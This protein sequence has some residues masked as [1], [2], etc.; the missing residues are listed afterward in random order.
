MSAFTGLSIEEFNRLYPMIADRY[1]DYEKKR[2]SR[3]GRKKDIGQGRKF[4]LD[5]IDRLLMLLVYYRLYITYTLAGFLFNLDQSNVYRNIKHL[6]PLVKE[7]IPL[8]DRVH[9]ATKKIKNLE[10][11]LKYFPEMK[12]FLDAT[13][14]E[15]PRPKN[16]RRRK[17]YYSGKKKRHTVKTQ[18]ITNKDGLIIH[19]TGHVHG[20]KHDYDLFKDKHP[21]IPKDV[22]MN[23]DLG[24][25]GID[26]DFPSLKSRIPIHTNLRFVVLKIFDFHVKRKRGKVLEK[27]E[28]RCNKKFNRT[29]VV[30][31]HAIGRMKKFKIM[32]SIFRNRLKTIVSG[33]TNFRAMISSGFDLNGFVA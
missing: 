14:Q 26:K 23:V 4:K 30:V 16:K 18:I 31:E 12:A 15:I 20:R 9:K 10:E 2:L 24:Y 28:K 7:C 6:E 27:K 19:K 21:P 11:L 13:E 8:P 5:L 25:Q 3:E 29:R 22:E 32:G 1:E 17:S 33:L